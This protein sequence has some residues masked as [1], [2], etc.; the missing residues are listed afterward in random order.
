ASNTALFDLLQDH[1]FLLATPEG[2]A[3][4][5][6]IV[7]SETGWSYAF[8]L[9]K[10]SP[11]LIWEAGEER[12]APFAGTVA[13]VAGDIPEDA[14]DAAPPDFPVQAPV[15]EVPAISPKGSDVERLLEMFDM[16]SDKETPEEIPQPEATEAVPVKI[17]EPEHAPLS[18]IPFTTGTFR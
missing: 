7:T 2:K 3:I 12:P 4:W 15:S 17:A 6:A 10:L 1:G 8:T 13:V 5:K 9:L 14:M 18:A 16:P 11:A